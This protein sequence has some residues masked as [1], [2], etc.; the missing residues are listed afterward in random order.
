[1]ENETER[2]S[3]R[4]S[5]SH[6]YM[7]VGD[8]ERSLLRKYYKR[9]TELG[10]ETV[11]R[12]PRL[13]HAKWMCLK[14]EGHE[15]VGKINRWLGWIQCTLDYEGVFSLPET[16]EHTRKEMREYDGTK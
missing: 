7:S 5:S 3:K 6:S 8:P 13:Q 12:G 16:I 2:K 9:L 14:A 11:E 10:I 15:D 1:M 4:I